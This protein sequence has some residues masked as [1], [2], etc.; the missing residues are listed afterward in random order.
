[1]LAHGIA[2]TILFLSA[3]QL[4]A[5]HGST[6][7]ADIGAVLTRSRVLG[8]AVIVGTVAL[9]G[10]PPFALFASELSIARGLA[11]AH[12]AWALGIALA[13]LVIAFAALTTNMIRILLG[14]AGARPAAI[15]VPG[16]LATA[17]LAGAAGCALLG[18]TAGPLTHL[19]H[20]AAEALGAGA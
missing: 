10:L 5:A 14:D 9:L 12:L 13:F 16:T 18:V 17:L 8:T 7:I 3:G 19:F 11:G 1:V 4:Q 20:L 2:K 6:A 15:A